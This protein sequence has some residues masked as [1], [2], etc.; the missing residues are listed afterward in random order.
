MA[1]YGSIGVAELLGASYST[2]AGTFDSVFSDRSIRC[3]G[4]DQALVR[5][6]VA[7]NEKWFHFVFYDSDTVG[8]GSFTSP[9]FITDVGNNV[10]VNFNAPGNGPDTTIQYLNSSVLVNGLEGACRVRI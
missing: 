2:V 10:L 4:S 8:G 3:D 1:T 9:F 5:P 7:G 6:T